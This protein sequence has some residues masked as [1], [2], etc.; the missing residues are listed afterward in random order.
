MGTDNDNVELLREAYRKWND[1]KGTD[2]RAWLDVM[3]ADV[4]FRSLVDRTPETATA[5]DRRS[6]DAVERYFADIATQWQMVHFTADH[7]IAQG[8]RVAV[9]GT[10][11]WRGRATGMV[12]ESPMAHFFRFENG[13]IVDICEFF[14]TAAGQ[15]ALAPK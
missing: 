11:A 10:C 2:R 8:D 12:A 14:D 5:P 15:A 13:R 6:R 4:R 9:L 3:A 7:Y 1:S